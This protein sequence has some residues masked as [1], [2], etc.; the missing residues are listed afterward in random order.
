[1]CGRAC[2]VCVCP[3]I[4]KWKVLVGGSEAGDCWALTALSTS[5]SSSRSSRSLSRSNSDELSV[6]AD[7]SKLFTFSFLTSAF[8]L[9]L[10]PTGEGSFR[11]GS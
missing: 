5:C 4:P 11:S 10:A 2:V 9:L 7:E 8:V 6:D 3:G 1:V